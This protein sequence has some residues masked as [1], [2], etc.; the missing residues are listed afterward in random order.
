MT[1][2]EKA[3]LAELLVR[4]APAIRVLGLQ[5]EVINGVEC[6]V[7][8]LQIDTDLLERDIRRLKGAKTA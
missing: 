3:E 1:P 6:E 2:E 8:G 4:R 7:F 5:K